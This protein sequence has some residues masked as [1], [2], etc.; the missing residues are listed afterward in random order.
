MLQW[1]EPEDT[2]AVEEG[3]A[4]PGVEDAPPPILGTEANE[5]APGAVDRASAAFA[6]SIGPGATVESPACVKAGTEHCPTSSITLVGGSYAI[7]YNGCTSTEP[8]TVA[9]G[10]FSFCSWTDESGIGK[11]ETVVTLVVTLFPG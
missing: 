3:A 8:G 9:T 2:D 11:P 10:E 6:L 4:G 1:K 5:D 7:W